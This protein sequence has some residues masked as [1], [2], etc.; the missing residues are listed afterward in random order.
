MLRYPPASGAENEIGAGAHTDY[1][2]LTVLAERAA[3]GE[4]CIA[5]AAGLLKDPVDEDTALDWQKTAIHYFYTGGTGGGDQA[6][7]QPRGKQHG[8]ATLAKIG[9]E[10]EQVPQ[11][12]APAETPKTRSSGP[13]R[14]SGPPACSGSSRRATATANCGMVQ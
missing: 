14:T 3:D 5:I 4:R 10:P 2:T 6:G 1:G 11:A 13:T 9:G 7:T 8:R 12:A